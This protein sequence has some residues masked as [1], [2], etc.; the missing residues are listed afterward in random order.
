[1]NSDRLGGSA[2]NAA[3]RFPAPFRREGPDPGGSVWALLRGVLEAPGN[4]FPAATLSPLLRA[5][6]RVL[7]V[8]F[9]ALSG[10]GGRLADGGPDEGAASAAGAG[11]DPLVIEILNS[12]GLLLASGARR[13]F[14]ASPL[15]QRWRA[16][17]LAALPWF[18]GP[19]LPGGLV[20][21][22]SARPGAP[23][24]AALAALGGL[25][26]A[27]SAW[28][29]RARAGRREEEFSGL[30]QALA[31]AAPLA[32]L[33]ADPAGTIR[34]ARGEWAGL[35]GLPAHP[36]GQALHEVFFA[37]PQAVE[38]LRRA[39]RGEAVRFLLHHGGK[40]C[41]A[42]ALPGAGGSLWVVAVEV[43]DRERLEAQL[44]Q[45]QKMEALGRL[46]GG[47]AHDFNNILTAI[48][49]HIQLALQRLD[50]AA[51]GRADL[52]TALEGTRRAA[53]LTRQLLAH[54]RRG[55]E[56]PRVL[57]L[58]TAIRSLAGML[59]RIIGEDVILS[60]EPA[61]RLGRTRIDLVH[62][63]QVLLNLAV[64]ARDA[65]PRG[66]RLV[67]ETADV[68]AGAGDPPAWPELPP[69]DYVMLAVSDTGCGMDEETRRRLFEPFFTTKEEGKGTGLGLSI[70]AGIVRRAGGHIL[71]WSR[72]G[73]GAS[74]RVFLPRTAER[75]PTTFPDERVPVRPGTETI[76]LV[77]DDA[78]VR[79]LA[80]RFLELK[81]YT[82]LPA[83]QGSAALELAGRF[84]GK[85]DLLI[86]D[87]VLPGLS[88]GETA[89]RFAALRPGAR[90]LFM[91][92]YGRESQAADPRLPRDAVVL[93]KP[94]TLDGLVR[95]VRRT[96]DL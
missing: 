90:V 56:E 38:G 33:E 6:A 45:A 64:N 48:S 62:V 42:R 47:V 36:Q 30:W 8:D 89:E 19:G 13:R 14:P 55:A 69:G 96:L 21:A 24:P 66:G 2:K 79:D 12:Q 86:T 52:E 94:F 58:N 53:G 59:R 29:E 61:P 77:E 23:S 7:A 28:C 93:S 5:A 25:A 20:A 22:G 74:F 71:V 49:G 63:E 16:E 84:P 37:H 51:P 54:S 27:L 88:G 26:A 39:G 43:T 9:L 32:A 31:G 72:P 15:L 50:P 75:D 18:A 70:A 73:E 81:G 44:R 40:T 80:R 34:W 83:P 65:M 57:D 91:S 60:F 92:G 78:G 76:L 10:P 85:I 67:I 68:T 46:T 4:E 1:M 11:A 95:Q 87:L 41:E 17:A 82:V 35:A 3:G